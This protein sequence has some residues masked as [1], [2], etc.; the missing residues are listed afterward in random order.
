MKKNFI[1]I[2]AGSAALM[3]LAGCAQIPQQE[4]NVANGALEAAKKANAESYAPSQL[5][6][7][8]VSFDLAT[9]EL[10]VENKKLPFLRTYD[11]IKETLKS[12]TS[13]AQSAL[14]AAEAAKKQVRTE[15]EG[16]ISRAQVVVDSVDAM[17]KEAA[18]KKKN[19]LAISA[20]IDT[21]RTMI[22]NVSDQ[23]TSGDLL[24]AKEN[25]SAVQTKTDALVKNSEGLVPAKKAL[26][27]K[28]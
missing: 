18:K 24:T 4:L 12:A 15:T 22:K 8:Q 23:I 25:A 10:N 28:R 13:A 14:A 20:D 5:K 1:S 19:T 17:V 2:V 6:A 3:V 7:A 16:L 26:A 21:L 11:K 9:N 27:K